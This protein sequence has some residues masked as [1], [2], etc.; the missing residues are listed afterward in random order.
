ML[1]TTLLDVI[2]LSGFA[3]HKFEAL[4][5]SNGKQALQIAVLEELP[6]FADA[7]VRE[8][9]E[10]YDSINPSFKHE[11]PDQERA[12]RKRFMQCPFY[13]AVT[14]HTVG[15]LWV[16]PEQRIAHMHVVV[17]NE[18]RGRGI[19][20][21]LLSQF[22]RD[23]RG[24]YAVLSCGWPASRTT[25]APEMFKRAGYGIILKPFAGSARKLLTQ[26]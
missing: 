4:K 17:A 14:E 9:W 10:L 15:G 24:K 7:R 21:A 26:V 25:N 19:G 2:P 1:E 18:V 8:F 6:R 16:D 23:A 20:S 12:E 3:I 5:Y 11:S 22:E 13:V